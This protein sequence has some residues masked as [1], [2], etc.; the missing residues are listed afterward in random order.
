MEAP[1]RML[2]ANPR[3]VSLPHEDDNAPSIDA[4]EHLVQRYVELTAQR[5]ALEEQIAV[6]RAELEMLASAALN[7]ATPKGRFVSPVGHVTAR[8]QPTCVFDRG[9]VYKQLQRAGRL[10]DVAT[11]TGPQLARFLA[12]E[13]QLAARLSDFIRYRHSVVLHSLQ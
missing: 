9:E 10:A 5:R 6:L 7:E 8:L 13:P 1:S 2:S 4:P 3:A 11:V 12:R